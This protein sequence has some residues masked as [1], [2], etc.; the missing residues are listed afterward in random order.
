MARWLQEAEEGAAAWEWGTGRGSLGRERYVQRPA[1]AERS[2]LGW[3]WAS[4]CKGHMGC[5]H[6]TLEPE[7]PPP[8]DLSALV[9]VSPQPQFTVLKRGYLPTAGSRAWAES[10]CV[11]PS[12]AMNVR[13][14][15]RPQRPGPGPLACCSGYDLHLPAT[16]SVCV[17][18]R[19]RV[20]GPF[21]PLCPSKVLAAPG[22][23]LPTLGG[24][25]SAPQGEVHCACPTG[26]RTAPDLLTLAGLPVLAPLLPPTP[27]TRCAGQ[28][29]A[30]PGAPGWAVMEG[31][32]KGR[33]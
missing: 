22:L 14:A 33:E 30:G 23:P 19:M 7:G 6:R 24:P 31:A 16:S 21:P 8:T 2:F 29:A 10:R 15:G 4:R 20:S 1:N 32:C 25:H 17:G 26:R 3:G 9:W 27:Q 18:G 28:E 11:G 5:L 12:G 13:G